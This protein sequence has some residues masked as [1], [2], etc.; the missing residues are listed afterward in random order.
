MR[1]NVDGRGRAVDLFV[2]ATAAIATV[3]AAVAGLGYCLWCVLDEP[4]EA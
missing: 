3:T 1:W 4:N 2:I